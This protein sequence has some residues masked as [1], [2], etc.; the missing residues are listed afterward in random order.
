MR[1]EVTTG[2]LNGPYKLSQ[3]PEGTPDVSRRLPQR[4]GEFSTLSEALDYAARGE[5]GFNFYSSRGELEKVLSYAELKDLSVRTAKRLVKLGLKRGDRVAVIADTHADFLSVFFGCQYAGLIPCPVPYNIFLGGKDA[6]VAR[7]ASMMR[8][9]GA[10]VAIAAEELLEPVAA[11]AAQAGIGTVRTHSELAGI[12][13]GGVKLSPFTPEEAA[14]I[15]YSSGSTSEPKGVLIT[16]RSIT[17]NARG[18]LQHGLKITPGDRAFS[19]LPL[20]HDMGLVGFCIAPMMGQVSTDYLPTTA[21]ARRP[22]LWLKL[23]SDNRSTVTYSPTFG[24]QLAGRRLNGEAA[25]LDLSA[26]RVAGI[27]GDMVRPDVLDEFAERMKAANFDPAAFLPSYGMA[28]STLGI[29]FAEIDRPPEVDVID[30]LPFKHYGRA[31]PANLK[32]RRNPELVRSFVICGKPLP[33]HEVVVV[34]KVGR[35][36]GDRQVGRIVHQRSKP[37]GRLFRQRGSHEGRHAG[38]RVHGHRRHGISH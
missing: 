15:Q 31:V 35:P 6:Y 21:F 5:T 29:A 3:P 32:S 16:Q 36:L 28:E 38:Q 11:A 9:A 17:S 25:N 19:W 27:G 37:H 4:L 18:I 23:M 33:G 12:A 34:D 2:S 30:R 1:A 26:L 13:E 24:Y 20:Y 14:Y 22:A 10:A 7:I 8:C